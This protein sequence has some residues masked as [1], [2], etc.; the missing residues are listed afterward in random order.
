MIGNDI[1]DLKRIAKASNWQRSRFL[2]K[3]F[4]KTEQALIFSSGNQHQIVWLLWSMKEAAYKVYVQQFGKHFF[5]PIKLECELN[6]EGK[7][8]VRI[9]NDT[10]FTSSI[11]TED[12]IYSIAKH[13]KIQGV[14]TSIFK[15]DTSTYSNQSDTL[16][17]H[18]LKLISRR[19]GLGSQDLS[20]KKTEV[21]VPQ[22]F[23]GT[24]K[25][26]IAFSLTHCGKYC[27][28]SILNS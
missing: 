7:G 4:T 12:Y 1:V 6:V 17:Q 25:L 23:N 8:K 11:I 21:G 19:D 18:V 27:G 5:N 13:N 9:A 28:Y 24:E 20:I 26:P 10:Y 2:D 14:S 3:V 15:L 22:I 16:K